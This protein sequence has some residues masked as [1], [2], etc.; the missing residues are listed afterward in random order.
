VNTRAI[1]VVHQLRCNVAGYKVPS[2]F[3]TV[4]ALLRNPAGK[5]VKAKLTT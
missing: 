3:E 1:S 2:R 4:D 5:V